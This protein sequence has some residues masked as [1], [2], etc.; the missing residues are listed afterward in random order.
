MNLTDAMAFASEAWFSSSSEQVIY[1]GNS[2]SAHIEYGGGRSGA[3]TGRSAMLTVSPMDVAKPEYR[4]S[5]VIEGETWRV[6][7]NERMEAVIRGDRYS[8]SIPITCDERPRGR[9]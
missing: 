5:V 6:F 1:N 9:N 3:F 4:D 8:W 2:I 7:K